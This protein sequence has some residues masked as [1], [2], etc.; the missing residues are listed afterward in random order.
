MLL[1]TLLAA[2]LGALG[3]CDDG[4]G[5]QEGRPNLLLITV[6]TL[7]ADR[8]G[9]YGD[10][11]A[12]TPHID[13]LARGGVLFESA[14]TPI[15]RTTQAVASIFT[16]LHPY[17]HGALEIGE[18]LPQRA[19]TLAERLWARG[20]ATLGVSANGSAS[21]LQGLDQGFDRFLDLRA[22]QRRHELRRPGRPPRPGEV[23]KAEAVTH[24]ALRWLEEGGEEPWFVWLL[25]L[26]PH[27]LYDPPPEWIGGRR[28]YRHWFY[29]AMSGFRP[30]L[31]SVYF[32]LGGRSS[33]ARPDLEEF[34]DGEIAYIDHWVGRLLEA[35]R[36]RGE[37]EN[38]LVVFT[39]DHGESLGEHGYFYEH[40][41]YVYEPTMRV[42]LILRGPA[43]V[44]EGRRIPEPVSLLDVVPTV[45][46]LLGLELEKEELSGRDLVPRLRGAPVEADRILFGESGSA[47]HVQTPRRVVGGRRSGRGRGRE[48][49]TYVRNG[50]WAAVRRG[51]D[52]PVALYQVEEDPALRR[53]RGEEEP[54]RLE[55]LRARLEEADLLAGRWRMALDGRF[56]LL[57]IP[58]WDGPSYELYDLARDPGEERNRIGEQPDRAARLRE[59]LD[60]WTRKAL[61]RAPV[62]T[63]RS[64]EEDATVRQRLRS[65]G[66]I[67]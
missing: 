57:R 64:R 62:P 9:A 37:A 59:A 45:A 23:Q 66:Y 21:R 6:D 5:G 15:P 42:P 34:Y 10:E 36:R 38:T 28:A 63:R 44:P 16:S 39:S 43:G 29:D 52:T 24:E 41:A 49:F 12:R 14:H 48:A 40:G 61:D 7:R 1:P 65:L 53:D 18:T 25:Y 11:D 51:E 35:L 27:F 58:G 26:E 47:L 33:K 4:A 19:V 31:P 46:S 60:A 17:E 56:K 50:P 30:R 67:E 8:L 32:D 13:A 54:E 55:A 20:Y 22:L 2:L 3:G